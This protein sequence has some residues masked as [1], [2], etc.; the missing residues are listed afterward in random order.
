MVALTLHAVVPDGTKRIATGHN[1]CH[2][3]ITIDQARDIGGIHWGRHRIRVQRRNTAVWVT[4]LGRRPGEDDALASIVGMNTTTPS[5]WVFRPFTSNGWSAPRVVDGLIRRVR[6][7]YDADTS[8]IN[9]SG[10]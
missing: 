8:V 7:L 5:V 4:M 3:A 2:M 1:V 6:V 9:I 10:R